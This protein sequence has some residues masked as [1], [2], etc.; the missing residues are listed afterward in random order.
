MEKVKVLV[1]SGEYDYV[2][3]GTSSSGNLSESHSVAQSVIDLS[4]S[5]S[6]V[7]FVGLTPEFETS[8]RFSSTVFQTY[9]SKADVPITDVT[10]VSKQEGLY[11]ENYFS[12][13]KVT[14]LSTFPIFCSTLFCRVFYKENYLYTD[15]DHLS[16]YGAK[17]LERVLASPY[18]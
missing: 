8:V 7:V 11:L 1:E 14:Y 18:N 12:R 6:K 4:K 15:G 2:F 3:I 16:L 9:A 5:R 13:S 17:L 10:T